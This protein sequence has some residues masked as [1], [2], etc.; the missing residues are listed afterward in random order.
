M[1]CVH[2]LGKVFTFTNPQFIVFF[3]ITTAMCTMP[4]T[5]LDMLVI[6]RSNCLIMQHSLINCIGNWSY[7][8]L[9]AS[10]HLDKAYDAS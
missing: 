1:G 9:D 5:T 3:H 2:C 4:V 7:L 8:Q 6:Q 10:V